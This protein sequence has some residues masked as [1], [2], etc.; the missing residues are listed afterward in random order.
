VARRLLSSREKVTA[1]R[2]LFMA[3]LA[4]SFVDDGIFFHGNLGMAASG[5]RRCA[6]PAFLAG[7][8]IKRTQR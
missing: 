1:T 5:P 3:C 6:A 8:A 2:T 7:I 4:F